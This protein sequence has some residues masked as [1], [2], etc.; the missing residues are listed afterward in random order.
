M[1]RCTV[2]EERCIG[3]DSNVLSALLLANKGQSAVTHNDPL[4]GERIATFRLFLYCTP[5]IPPSVTA[6]AGLI[7]DGVKLEEHL[8]FIAG[9]FGEIVPD[10]DQ[11]ELIGDRAAELLRF[12]NGELD[13]RIVAESE[14]GEVAVLVSLDSRLVTRLSPYTSVQLLR[15]TDL[16]AKLALAPGTSPKWIPGSGHPLEFATW[17]RW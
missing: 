5:F 16:W 10:D 4:E 13:C 11:L 8:R 1:S 2:N 15:P 9:S 14:V 7:P 12:H 17:W 3:F 6:E